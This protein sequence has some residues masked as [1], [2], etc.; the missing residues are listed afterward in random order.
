MW[1]G[2]RW[3]M[4]WGSKGGGY[5]SDLPRP[6]GRLWRTLQRKL[7]TCF[8]ITD[9]AHPCPRLHEGVLPPVPYCCAALGS[10]PALLRTHFPPPHRPTA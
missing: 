6:Q 7:N 8:A 9:S 3:R 10:C 4:A 5:T 2:E 1:S